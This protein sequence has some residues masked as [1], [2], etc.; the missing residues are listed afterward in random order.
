MCWVPSFSHRVQ[1]AHPEKDSGQMGGIVVVSV[2]VSVG[3]CPCTVHMS[4]HMS[5]VLKPVCVNSSPYNVLTCSLSWHVCFCV[6]VC[7]W[8]WPG[9]AGS[10][11][12][13]PDPS[14]LCNTGTGAAVP[15]FIAGSVQYNVYHGKCAGSTPCQPIHWAG[16]QGWQDN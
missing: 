6:C 1:I 4:L 9:F 12:F 8:F 3:H 5:E 7:V 15:Q 2:S 16:R 13:T 11:L 14:C 10:P